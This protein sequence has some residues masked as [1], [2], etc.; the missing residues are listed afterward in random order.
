MVAIHA[1][2]AA[3]SVGVRALLKLWTMPRSKKNCWVD[4]DVIWVPRSDAAIGRRG[5]SSASRPFSASALSHAI[6]TTVEVCSGPKYLP[7][8][9]R[10]QA[11]STGTRW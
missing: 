4:F 10:E 1:S 9:L 11:S 3:L 8:I 6:C 2:H 5:A 7:V